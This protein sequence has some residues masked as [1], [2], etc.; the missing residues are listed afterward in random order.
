MAKKEMSFDERQAL[1]HSTSS[2]RKE[3]FDG[4]LKHLR[5]GFSV[6]CYSKCSVRLIEES[7]KKYPL[8]F[9]QEA[10]DEAMADGKAGWEALGKAQAN[11][12]C[13]GNSRTWFYNMAHRY[14]WSDRQTVDSNVSGSVSVNVVNYS[15][16]KPSSMDEDA[17]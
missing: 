11:G 17:Q 8:E 7:I 4:L 9:R 6:D 16:P 3:V 14:K 12:T 1:F 10:I 5:D 13:M 2:Y 15:R